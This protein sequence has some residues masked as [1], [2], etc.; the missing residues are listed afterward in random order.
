MIH[1]ALLEMHYHHSMVTLFNET[2][3]VEMF[4][5]LKPSQQD[6]RWVG[7]D[8]GWVRTSEDTG[9]FIRMLHDAV[10]KGPPFEKLYLGYF[11]QFKVVELFSRSS[12]YKPDDFSVPY[13]RSEL[14]L[15]PDITTGISQHETLKR[16]STI[17]TALVYYAC[18]MLFNDSDLYREADL[19]GLRLVKVDSSPHGWTT[20]ERHFI[21][22]QQWDDPSP[23]WHS[24]PVVT[25]A[26][27]LN[28]LVEQGV[29][30][31][32]TPLELINLISAVRLSTETRKNKSK[33]T[34]FIHASFTVMEFVREKI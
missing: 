31:L 29:M 8:Q 24:E 2:F 19:S 12:R 7:F 33:E 10:Q 20:N 13:L 30:R 6:E 4:R 15:F 5:I 9:T 1:E 11:L 21:V 17:P 22:F 16:L 18:P 32:L 26:V 25:E 34:P 27:T 14:S 23:R 3:G 28:N